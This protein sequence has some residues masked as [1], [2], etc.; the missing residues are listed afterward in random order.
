MRV[1]W[2][3]LLD[4]WMTRETFEKVQDG[5]RRGKKFKLM[6]AVLGP[7]LYLP[8]LSC[9]MSSSRTKRHFRQYT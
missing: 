9:V 2:V 1:G 5:V 6:L 3:D 8:V 7:E 4:V